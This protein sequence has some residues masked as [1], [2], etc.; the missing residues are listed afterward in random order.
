VGELEK[1]LNAYIESD[2]RLEI[3][4]NYPD[5]SEAED[6]YTD[7]WACEQV[8]AEFAAFARSNGWD[9]VVLRGENPE[10]PMAF[11]HA[12]V[13]VTRDGVVS[14]V[15]WTARQFHNLF[16]VS[17]DPAVL[18][19]P[20]PLAWDP[21]AIAPEDHLIVGQYATVSKEDQ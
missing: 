15:D 7:R 11:D 2:P 6:D 21:S 18:A 5:I 8:S 14:D 13:R 20:W 17:R 3:W 1:L 12:W 19:L 9:A 10:A 4:R 16:C